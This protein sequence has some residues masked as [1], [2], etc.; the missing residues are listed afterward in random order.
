MILASSLTWPDVAALAIG[1]IAFV[2]YMGTLA[3]GKW[4]WE[5]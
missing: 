1:A 2:C 3:T 4:P 5:K